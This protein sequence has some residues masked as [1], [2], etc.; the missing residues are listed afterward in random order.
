MRPA[1]LIIAS[2]GCWNNLNK[3]LFKPAVS[4]RTISNIAPGVVSLHTQYYI[5]ILRYGYYLYGGQMAKVIKS[6][7][8]LITRAPVPSC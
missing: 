2:D 8:A 1:A 7:N 3:D 4:S 6:N 5:N